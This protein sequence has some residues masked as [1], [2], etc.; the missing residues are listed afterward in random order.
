MVLGSSVPTIFPQMT[1]IDVFQSI[2]PVSS[3]VILA[4]FGDKI[5][6]GCWLT[7]VAI[8]NGGTNILGIVFV[9]VEAVCKVEQNVPPKQCDQKQ[10][11]NVYKSCPK[12]ISLEK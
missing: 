10:S 3:T 9:D 4:G 11:P 8:K 7:L 2:L 1:T 12:I 6:L 5:L